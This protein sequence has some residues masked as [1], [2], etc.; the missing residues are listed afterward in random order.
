MRGR[1]LRRC[2]DRS[3]GGARHDERNIGGRGGPGEDE[4]RLRPEQRG[5]PS[6]S[7][8]EWTRIAFAEQRSGLVAPRDVH[9]VTRHYPMTRE[10]GLVD[11]KA[12]LILHPAFDKIK[13]HPRQPPLGEPP[14]VVDIDRVLDFHANS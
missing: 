5:E 2:L 6:R 7:D 9:H 1:H 12:V 13:N 14:Q 4:I 11:F 10:A 8:S 3:G